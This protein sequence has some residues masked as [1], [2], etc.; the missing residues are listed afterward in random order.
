[1]KARAAVQIEPD[2]P[3]TLTHVHLRP[4]RADEVLVKIVACG[5]CHTDLMMQN[6]MGHYPALLGHEGAGVVQKTGSQVNHFKPGDPVVISYTY[7]GICENCRAG[8]P[9]ECDN[10]DDYFFG[11]RSDGSTPISCNG[12]PVAALLRQGAFAEYAVCHRNSL[13]KVDTDLDLRTLAPLGCG[14]QTGAG[15]V[16]NILKP[17]PNSCLAVFGTGSVGLAAV[18]A[19][20][21]CDCKTIIAVDQIESRLNMAK[22]LGATHCIHSKKT[23]DVTAAIKKICPQLDCGLDTSGDSQLLNALSTALKPGG[24]ACGVGGGISPPRVIPKPMKNRFRETLFRKPL[25]LK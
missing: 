18:A 19:A 10:F 2:E 12:R 13:V 11:F 5:I 15:S 16:C 21:V 1:M 6:S 20:A 14:L 17:E 7:C 24:K 8:R 25:F 4:P 9:Y 3:L 22:T 23:N